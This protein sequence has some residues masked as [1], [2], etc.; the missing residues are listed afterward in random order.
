MNTQPESNGRARLNPAA[1]LWA[2]VVV[3]VALIIIQAGRLTGGEARADLVAATGGYTALT[4]EIPA[5][6]VLLVA[7]N[8]SEQIMVY[9]VVNQ[10]SLDLF[11][12]YSLPR[13]FSDA[14]ARATGGRR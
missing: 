6:D 1:A 5:E 11:R 7:D 2:S 14:R 9:K 10:S 13:L 4:A 12:T 8:R 3:L